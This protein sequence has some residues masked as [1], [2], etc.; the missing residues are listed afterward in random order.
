MSWWHPQS[1]QR[2][3]RSQRVGRR[4][5]ELGPLAVVVHLARSRW[6]NPSLAALA[7][8]F[9][10]MVGKPL[11][12]KHPVTTRPALAI[13]RERYRL[14]QENRIEWG[15]VEEAARPNLCHI[16]PSVGG[17][18]GLASPPWVV[19]LEQVPLMARTQGRTRLRS[20]D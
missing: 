4:F 17:P 16:V 3:K 12:R 19:A 15:R 14:A 8:I 1:W 2:S 20:C 11:G 10:P 7:D 5:R 6:Q 13:A 9:G 18:I